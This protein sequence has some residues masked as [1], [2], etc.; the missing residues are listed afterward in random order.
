[1]QSD[2]YS[3]AGVNIDA[4]NEAVSKIKD[5][6]KATFSPFVLTGLGSFG[7][8][9]DIKEALKNYKHPILVQSIDGVGTKLTVAKLMNKYDTVGMDIVNHCCNDI[10]AMGAKPLTFLD[11]IAN[12]KLEPQIVADIVGGMA[13]ACQENN[14]SLIGGETAE[15]PGVY[16]K[17]EHDIAGC[18]TGVVEKDKIITGQ[19]IEPGDV[20]LGFAS[21]GL[22]TNGYSLAR[23]IFFEDAKH[24]V[25][26][27]LPELKTSLGEALLMPHTSYVK[28]IFSLLDVGVEIKGIVHITGGGFIDN[29]PRILPENCNAEI[30]KGSWPVLPIFEVMAK[31]GKVDELTMYRTFNMG[32]GLI[33]VSDKDQA[34]KIKEQ[35]VYEIGK[36]IHGNRQVMFGPENITLT[37][38]GE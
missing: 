32:I 6:V 3:Q 25:A 26:D 33:V 20:V 30:K 27:H 36:I 23:K 37:P 10:L 28:Q 22:H 24:K 21:N 34:A 13:K 15:M 1:M 19:N 4:G 29:I 14:C 17:G 7:A 8:L 38:P 16:N 5:R 31:L 35:G 9:F 18:I 2:A 12:E 11:Y